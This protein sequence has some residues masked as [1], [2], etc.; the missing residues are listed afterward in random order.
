VAEVIEVLCQACGA[1]SVACPSGVSE[2]KG[3]EKKEIFAM[4]EAGLES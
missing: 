3:F 4:I 1:C 2:Q